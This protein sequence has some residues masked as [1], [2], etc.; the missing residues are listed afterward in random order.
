[1]TNFKNC[2]TT[3]TLEIT[4]NELKEY[5]SEYFDIVRSS[6]NGKSLF[7][8]EVGG[9]TITI[10]SRRGEIGSP[11]CGRQVYGFLMSGFGK[12]YTGAHVRTVKFFRGVVA[13]RKFV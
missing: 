8:S 4:L 5:Y 12:D 13:A 6:G 2:V 9:T 3:H 1:M 7:V 11:P 10:S